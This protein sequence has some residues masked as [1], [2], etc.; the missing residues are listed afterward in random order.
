MSLRVS[1]KKMKLMSRVQ[2][3]DL[4]VWISYNAPLE[5]YESNYSSHEMDK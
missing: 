2:M 4:A 3:Q 5:S 1:W